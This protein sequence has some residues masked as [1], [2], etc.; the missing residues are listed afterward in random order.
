MDRNKGLAWVT[1]LAAGAA[2][3]YFLDPVQGRRRREQVRDRLR[4]LL[5]ESEA[6]GAEAARPLRR[7]PMI[8]RSADEV[9][10]EDRTLV[11]RVCSELMRL[12]SNPGS[13]EVDADDAI[14]TL[15]GSIPE[16]EVGRLLTSLRHLPGLRRVESLLYT[17]K[18][19]FQRAEAPSPET[20]NPAGEADGPGEGEWSPELRLG[21]G[22]VGTLLALWGIRRGDAPGVIAAAAGGMALA[23]AVANVPPSR[24]AGLDRSIPVERTVE[25]DAPIARV[26]AFWSSF[27][28][29]PR[30]MQ[31]LQE[32]TEDESGVSHW[33]ADGPAGL[34][35]SWKAEVTT[36]QPHRAIA[37]RSLPGST[38]QSS[39]EVM[40]EELEGGRTRLQVKMIYHPPAGV[41]GHAVA[42][43][44]GADPERQIEDDLQSFRA[45][46]EEGSE[47]AHGRPIAALKA[48]P[49]TS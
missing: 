38:V 47:T 24:M 41:V 28:N 18:S 26:F 40:F 16:H 42:R 33:V 13:I 17:V 9:L 8:R 1:A 20:A 5:S 35:V 2:A 4:D 23:R 32:V 36:L 48:L 31:H 39:G 11:E 6:S 44:F 29:F 43:F 37:W 14:V 3:I 49:E 30:F 10:D 7:P 27:R 46:L 34:P 25:V 45:L 12:T 15:R 21:V 19:P 22:T